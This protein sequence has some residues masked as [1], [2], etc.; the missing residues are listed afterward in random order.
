ML[1]QKDCSWL[2]FSEVVVECDLHRG[3]WPFRKRRIRQVRFTTNCRPIRCR[4]LDYDP[5]T[6]EMWLGEEH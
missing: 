5:Q 3:W 2:E 6:G 1:S 4:W